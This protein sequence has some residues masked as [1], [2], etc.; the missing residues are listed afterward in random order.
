LKWH[1]VKRALLHALDK[2]FLPAEPSDGPH[3]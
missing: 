3:R 1:A 2:V